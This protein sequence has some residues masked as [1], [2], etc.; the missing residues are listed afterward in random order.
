MWVKYYVLQ[1]DEKIVELCEIPDV[2]YYVDVLGYVVVDS[3]D[4][5]EGKR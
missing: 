5:K 4:K 1:K 3:V 2:H